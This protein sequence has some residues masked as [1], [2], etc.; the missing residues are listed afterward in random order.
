M[1]ISTVSTSHI[2]FFALA[3]SVVTVVIFAVGAVVISI[4]LR[5]VEYRY[6]ADSNMFSFSSQKDN[7]RKTDIHYNDVI[8][9]KYEERKLFGFIKRGFTVTVMT[10]SLGYIKLDYLFNKSI[11]IHTPE[12]TPFSIIEKR[13]EMTGEKLRR[14]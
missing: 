11:K 4:I 5:G 6:T 1:G 3:F 12:N 10:H 9:V 13:A 2:Q 14:L 7:V 8:A